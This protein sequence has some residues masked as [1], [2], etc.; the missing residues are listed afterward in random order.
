MFSSSVSS[1]NVLNSKLTVQHDTAVSVVSF[2]AVVH[3]L[4]QCLLVC[5]NRLL[6]APVLD[7]QQTVQHR[8]K[9][10][11]NASE[12][13]KS[14]KSTDLDT[15]LPFSSY[16]VPPVSGK[17]LIFHFWNSYS[18]PDHCRDFMVSASPSKTYFVII[19]CGHLLG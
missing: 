17:C 15:Y 14:I 13:D 10:G 12:I 19:F 3:S 6:P 2:S 11:E 18:S 4:M 1:R 8:D 9:L 5:Q 16:S 7:Q